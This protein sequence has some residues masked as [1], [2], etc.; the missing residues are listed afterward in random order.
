VE[1]TLE[2][3]NPKACPVASERLESPSELEARFATKRQLQWVGYKAHLTETC[4]EDLPHLVTQV[5]TTSAPATDVA[6]LARIQDA[7]AARLLL[8]SEHL[9]DAAY[10]RALNLVQSRERYQIDLVGPVD[11]D[12]R[13]QARVEGGFTSERFAIDLPSTGRRVRRSARAASAASA[14]ARPPQLVNAA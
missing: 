4:D 5:T 2:W 8:P 1:G 6:Q 12:H 13:W 7:L 14:G 10:V 9:V 11:T 3:R